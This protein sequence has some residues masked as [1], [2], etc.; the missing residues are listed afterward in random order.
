MASLT[1]SIVIARPIEDVFAVITDVEKTA[2]WFPVDVVETW[3][4]PPPHGVGSVRHAV[5]NVMGQRTEND[6]T[7]TEFDPPRHGVMVGEQQGVR[8][9]ATV[10][11]AEVEGGT[12]LDM[13]F[14]FSAGGAMRLF[15]G[16]FMNWYGN[17]WTTGLA[18]LKRM[19]EAGEL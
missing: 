19:M 3:T 13:T 12:R 9:S 8:F 10:E 11:C 18:N 15:I 5:V 14:E 17:W 2:R 6:A 4:T 16:T 7:V 1:R